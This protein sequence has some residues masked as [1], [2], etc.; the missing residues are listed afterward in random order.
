MLQHP[1]FG[2]IK[3]L[4]WR[5]CAICASTVLECSCCRIHRY[6]AAPFF[7]P[8]RF[9]VWPLYLTVLCATVM[10][11]KT[12]K[13]T[14]MCK[15][16]FGVQLLLHAPLILCS[17][18]LFSPSWIPYCLC[19][20]RGCAPRRWAWRQ[21][22]APICAST[23]LECGCCRIHRYVTA[24]FFLPLGFFVWP[25]Y[26]TGLCTTVMSVKTRKCTDMY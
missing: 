2:N 19:T 14:G 26:L 23:V 13:C 8:L 3:S 18:T 15:H 12:R 7:L 25:L 1:F 10:S 4:T 17:S 24:P 22:N 16:C 11:V 9:S 21:G 5:G 20:W 6:V